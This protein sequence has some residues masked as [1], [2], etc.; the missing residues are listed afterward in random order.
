[1]EPEDRIASEKLADADSP[2]LELKAGP[3]APADAR[4]LPEPV[5]RAICRAPADTKK[6]P[7]GRQAVL[8]GGVWYLLLVVT[9]FISA[10]GVEVLRAQSVYNVACAIPAVDQFTRVS[11]LRNLQPVYRNA[12]DRSSI[13]VLYRQVRDGYMTHFSRSEYPCAVL[14]A[15]HDIYGAGGLTHDICR[16]L[17]T[18]LP[19]LRELRQSKNPGWPQQVLR[20]KQHPDLAARVMRLAGSAGHIHEYEVSTELYEFLVSIWDYQPATSTISNLESELGH[21]Y[22]DWGQYEKALEMF[23]RAYNYHKY[24]RIAGVGSPLVTGYNAYR[25]AHMGANLVK[26][27]RYAEAEPLLKLSLSM[28][29]QLNHSQDYLLSDLHSNLKEVAA[30]GRKDRSMEMGR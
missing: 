12:G 21:T 27:G 28:V 29:R 22:E 24:G 4:A 2:G 11:A 16:E 19:V 30:A 17:K 9:I 8:P 18:L 23:T 13:Q 10:S 14:Y 1:M 26:L 15:V 6:N 5:A 7:A 25:L 3:E 20:I